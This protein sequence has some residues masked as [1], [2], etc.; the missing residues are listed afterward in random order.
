[1][2]EDFR[3]LKVDFGWGPYYSFGWN[4]ISH[5]EKRRQHRH[6]DPEQRWP[7][8]FPVKDHFG[9]KVDRLVTRS[10]IAIPAN[11]KKISTNQRLF[12]QRNDIQF[13]VEINHKYFKNVFLA[14]AQEFKQIWHPINSPFVWSKFTEDWGCQSQRKRFNV[15]VKVGT[16]LRKINVKQRSRSEWR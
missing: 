4:L 3:A 2:F 10:P 7:F 15:C 12:C 6:D 9:H 8:Q 11:K 5:V 1:M 13:S 14:H 16:I